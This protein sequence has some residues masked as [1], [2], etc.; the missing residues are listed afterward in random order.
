MERGWIE[1]MQ[2]LGLDVVVL[3]TIVLL[4]LDQLLRTARPLISR[5]VLARRARRLPA[6]TR[7]DGGRPAIAWPPAP[8][9]TSH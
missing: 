2:L 9:R 6:A 8:W 7:T 4:A 1:T 3:T 5:L